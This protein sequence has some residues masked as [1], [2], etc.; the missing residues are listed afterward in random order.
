[1]TV[2]KYAIKW[3]RGP[4]RKCRTKQSKN[5]KSGGDEKSNLLKAHVENNNYSRQCK[6]EGGGI[7]LRC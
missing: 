6:N 1:M 5:Y 2:Q 7:Q 4:F 3:R